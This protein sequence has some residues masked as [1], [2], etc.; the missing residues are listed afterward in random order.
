MIGNANSIQ[1]PKDI[2]GASGNA[3]LKILTNARF[4]GVPIKVAIPP[5]EHE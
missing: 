1:F 3:M 2:A 5:I 4:G